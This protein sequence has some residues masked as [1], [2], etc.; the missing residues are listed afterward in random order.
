[1]A[2][3]E[4]R[5]GETVAGDVLGR[6]AVPAAVFDRDPGLV[7]YGLEADLDLGILVGREGRLAPAKHQ[8]AGRRP[9]ADLADLEHLPA[10]KRG[11]EP[12]ALARLERQ[13]TRIARRE[14][15]HRAGLPPGPDITDERR[16]RAL[17]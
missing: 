16:E 8:S 2:R 1:M 5:V 14:G 17:G 9:D 7:A 3:Q 6:H 11:G 15:E 4:Q 12:T 13:H 10:R